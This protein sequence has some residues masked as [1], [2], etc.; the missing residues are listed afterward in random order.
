MK[1]LHANLHIYLLLW[2]KH[3]KKTNRT[4]YPQV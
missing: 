3:L 1:L 2:K 4:S